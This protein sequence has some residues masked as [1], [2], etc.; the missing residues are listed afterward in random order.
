MSSPEISAVFV[1]W[2]SARSLPASLGSLRRSAAAAEATVEIVVVDNSSA[3]DSTA[4]AARAGAD[5]IVENPLNAGY[6]VA[7]SQGIELSRSAWI[8]L[9]NP[10]LTVSEEFVGRM[11]VAAR[12]VDDDVACLVPDIRYAANPDVVNSRGIEV[13]EIGIPAESEAGL[14]AVALAKLT[15]VFGP[16]T[17]GCLIRRTA[18]EAV[19]GLEP[20]YFAYMEDVDVAWRLRKKGYRALVVPGAL[21]LHEGSAST[22]EGSWLKAFLVARNRRTLFRLHGPRGP[23]ARAFRFVTEIGHASVQALS[24]S[25]TA[26]IRGRAA[27]LRTWRYTRFLV[28]SSRVAGIPDDM[29]VELAPRRTLYEAW[30]RKRTA[31]SLMSRPEAPVRAP[32]VGASLGAPSRPHSVRPL[33]VL[34]D[35]T[36]PGR[37]GIQTYTVGLIDA[38]SARPELNLVV[39][40][41]IPELVELGPMQLVLVPPRTQGIVWRALW[42]ERNLASL[43]GSLNVDVTLTPVPQLPVRRLPVPTVVVVHDVGPLVAPRFYSVPKRLRYR[44]FLPWACRLASAVVCVSDATLRDLLATTSTDPRRCVVIGEGPQLL[45]PGAPDPASE[46]RPFLLY[47]G[48]LEPRKNVGTLVD[49][50]AG[51]GPEIGADLVIVG[52]T[53]NHASRA[54]ARQ[55][56]R[57]GLGHR[58]RH[59]GFVEPERLTALYRGAV[60][61]ALPS[62]YEGFGLPVLEAMKSGTPVVASDI[63]SLREIAG[64]A[65]LLVSRPLDAASWS[66]ALTRVLTDSAL[67]DELARRGPKAAELFDWSEV[68]ERFSELLHRVASHGVVS[69]P[70][71]RVTWLE[72]AG[73]LG[74]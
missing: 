69:D 73:R 48:S 2:N 20:L 9:V 42:R 12:S 8:M 17:S 35:A 57:L 68:G 31:V 71:A 61:V 10:D 46:G 64:D 3:D 39:V 63:P 37:G 22:G 6:V 50:I 19:G 36:T 66:A 27:A 4:V 55:I 47:V 33:H 59:L 44:T 67:R 40:T 7:A 62:L 41:S 56:A 38:L 16:S 18:L 5:T 30:R 54:L 23:R 15:D 52:P 43:A 28:A 11:L 70:K 53:E 32:G 21:A 49:A 58:V 24:G 60:A 74:G 26:P 29:L 34:V 72:A 25:G 1:S 65:A 45:A 14:R 13:D 51:L